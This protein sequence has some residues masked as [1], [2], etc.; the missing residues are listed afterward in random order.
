MRKEYV[1]F[2]W[3]GLQQEN[4]RF[5]VISSYIECCTERSSKVEQTSARTD[6]IIKDVYHFA[7]R[8]LIGEV[9]SQAASDVW[10][11]AKYSA[12]EGQTE[13]IRDE[14]RAWFLSEN[15]A[16]FSFMWCCHVGGYNAKLFR[17]G[18]RN[19]KFRP[20]LKRRLKGLKKDKDQDSG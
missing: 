13:T 6:E 15:R 14:A 4:S 20:L 7:V 17:D 9:I 10:G 16:P 11:G 2:L 5:L 18:V 19:P 12:I 1:L 8:R 3:L